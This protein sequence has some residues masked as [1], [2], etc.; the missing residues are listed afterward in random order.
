MVGKRGFGYC[1][2]SG[3]EQAFHFYKGVVVLITRVPF[4]TLEC[5]Q[6]QLVFPGQINF[7]LVLE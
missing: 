1:A 7:E 2:V 4:Q 6:L 5:P 3:L